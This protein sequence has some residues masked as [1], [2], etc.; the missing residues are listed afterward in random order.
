[1]INASK[2]RGGFR[3]CSMITLTTPI[4]FVEISDRPNGRTSLI[5]AL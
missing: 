3:V 4:R 5:E 1:M 2:T